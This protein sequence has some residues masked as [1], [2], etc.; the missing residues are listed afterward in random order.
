MGLQ[1]LPDPCVTCACPQRAPASHLPSRPTR[2]LTPRP[3]SP[4]TLPISCFL[5][6]PKEH[7]SVH[8]PD[9]H[10]SVTWYWVFS[11]LCPLGSGVWDSIMVPWTAR[12]TTRE[13]AL[14]KHEIYEITCSHLVWVG[15]VLFVEA[16]WVY[17]LESPGVS[18]LTKVR[19]S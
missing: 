4:L 12:K 3:S 18:C 14:N 11:C 5:A 17:M 13:R 7:N 2:C 16:F 6:L 19:M 8:L 9:F 15:P 10:K 1:T